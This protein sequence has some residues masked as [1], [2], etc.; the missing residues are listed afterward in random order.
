MCTPCKPWGYSSLH[1]KII[2][3]VLEI[4]SQSGWLLAKEK[5]ICSLPVSVFSCSQ[6]QGAVW[7]NPIC[8]GPILGPCIP[9]L[10]KHL[11][12]QNAL[13]GHFITYSVHLLVHANSTSVNHI[14][15]TRCIWACRRCEDDHRISQT[16][17]RLGFSRT[18]ILRILPRMVWSRKN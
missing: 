8:D 14:V 6:A 17:D 11:K 18:T 5:S 9:G 2:V 13:T 10:N 15:A 1:V 12:R 16:A 7:T 3:F 4:K